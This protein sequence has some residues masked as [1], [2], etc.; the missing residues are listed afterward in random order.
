MRLNL[1]L[2]SLVNG[3]LLVCALV[4]TTLL[5]NSELRRRTPSGQG[6]VANRF[7]DSIPSGYDYFA[8]GQRLGPADELPALVV[9]S[10]YE[11]P[12]C[13]LFHAEVEDRRKRGDHNLPVSYRHWPLPNHRN[14]E[15]AAVA[16]ECAARQGRFSAMHDSLFQRQREL[17]SIAYDQLARSAG[18]LDV[19]EF[20]TCM[21]D[22]KVLAT[23][24]N[25]AAL[26]ATLRSLGTP[27]VLVR[28]GTGF[29]GVLNGTALDTLLE[30]LAK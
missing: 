2:A 27:T 14:A 10:D 5:V 26:A 15:K 7:L 3:A 29:A 13:R 24:R 18:V 23:V 19:E 11:C 17:G 12:A 22:P 1:S 8:G 16:S 28:G 6:Q 9:F 21:L 20:N 4:V 25:D 30:S